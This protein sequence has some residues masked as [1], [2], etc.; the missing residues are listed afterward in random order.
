MLDDDHGVTLVNQLLKDPEKD[1]DVF[2]MQAGRGFVQYVQ[3][4]S[5]GL[6]EQ[7]GGKLH[8]LALPSREGYGALAEMDIS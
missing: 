1:L 8:P 5:C 3:G 4:V 6:T 2:E 7:F